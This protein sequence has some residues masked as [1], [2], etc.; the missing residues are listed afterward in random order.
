MKSIS[1]VTKFEPYVDEI[2]TTESKIG[3]LTNKDFS[4]K[5]AKTIKIYKISTANMNDY[6]RDNSIIGNSRYG[7]IQ[8]L[9]AT[10]EE[11]TLKKDRSFTFEI[12]KLDIDETLSTLSSAS[13]LSRQIREVCV[14]EI[15]KYIYGVMLE[16]AGNIVE[17]TSLNATNIYEKIIDANSTL[18]D[19]E[20]PENNRV[21]I[22]TPQTYLLL[23]K[24]KDII[25]NTNIG[26]ELRLKGVIGIL[27]GMNVVKVPQNRFPSDFGFLI[28]HP[29]AT[30]TAVKLNDFKIHKDPPGISGDLVEGRLVYD[31]FV[32]ENKKKAIFYQ[33]KI[34]G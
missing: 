19:A 16:N 13:A 3:L 24:S 18:D 22:V 12:D 26:N 20:V 7:T 34:I 32:L 25:L 29:V 27:D 21:L 8:T 5:G 33:K 31:A 9:D 6:N 23:K 15:D 28:A 10:T 30:V 17:P 1:L 14:P 2:F 4:W 11:M